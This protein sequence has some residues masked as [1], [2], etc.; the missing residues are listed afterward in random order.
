[1]AVIHKIRLSAQVT[2]KSQFEQPS[3]PISVPLDD[4]GTVIFVDDDADRVMPSRSVVQAAGRYDLHHAIM[5]QGGYR[6]AAQTLD[7]PH[8]WPRY[9]VLGGFLLLRADSWCM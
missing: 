2:G 4:E 9:Q 1:M 5:Y 8:T 7:R 6:E 3:S